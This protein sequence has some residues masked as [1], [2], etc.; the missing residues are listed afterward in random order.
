MSR[1]HTYKVEKTDKGWECTVLVDIEG[2]YEWF[3]CLT[4][5]TF[6][7]KEEAEAAGEHA[8]LVNEEAMYQYQD[9]CEETKN[10]RGE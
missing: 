5:N 3:D 1:P 7:T 4:N 9:K 2:K 8:L 6:S 10:F